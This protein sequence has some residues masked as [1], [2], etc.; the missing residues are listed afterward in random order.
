MHKLANPYCVINVDSTSNKAGQ[1]TEYVQAYVEIGSHKT[2]QYL[3]ITNLVNKEIMIGYLYLYKHNPNIN[4]QKGQQEFTR[5]PDTCTS[6]ACKIRDVEAE[7]NELYL[8]INVSGF[9]SLDDIGDEDPDNHILSWANMTDLDNYQQVMMIITILNN[10]DQYGNS[11]CKDTKTWKAHMPEWLHEYGNVFS[12]HKS[13]R[14]SLRKPYDYAINFMESAKLPK[15]TKVYPL[16]LVEK[17]SLDTQINEELR[18]DYI[19]LSTSP[20]AASFFFVKKYN[21]SLQLVMNYRALNAITVKNCYLIPRIA[22]L[23]ESLSKA[24]IFTKIDLRWV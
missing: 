23:I 20:I 2:T 5:C 1:I 17:N 16:S 4:W 9:P 7:A 11:D 18:K 21:G 24:S 13:E 10:R 19:Y 15:P 14:M 3:F 12:K 22:N 6:K 8:E